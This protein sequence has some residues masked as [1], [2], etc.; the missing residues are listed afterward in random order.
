M[1]I[2]Y[3]ASHEQFT[4]RALLDYVSR[5]EKAGFKAVMCS[6]HVSPWSVRQ[7][8]SGHPWPWLGAALQATSSMSFGTLSIPGGMRYHPVAIAQNFAT[9]AQM[10]PNRFQWIAAG[11]G[12]AMNETV[13]GETWPAREERM[14]RMKA[15]IDMIRKLW[16][17]ETITQNDGPFKAENAR[18]WTLPETPPKIYAAA[19]GPETARDAG[20][21]ADGLITVRKDVDTLNSIISAF[22]EGGGEG[23]PLALQLQVAWA[24][25]EDTARTEA[26]DQWRHTAAGAQPWQDF[27]TPESIDRAAEHVAPENMDE[28]LFISAD[29]AAHLAHIREHAAFGFDEIYIHNA[30]RNQA[31]FIEVFAREVLPSC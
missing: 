28:G 18:I 7:G 26:H 23:K 6:D 19:I 9:L 24:E 10:F 15:G 11:S 14:A 22:R 5:A 25:D 30:A 17:G 16:R 21:W 1:K 2:G 31:Q 3:H 13:T 12:E 27:R 29:P 20:A 8:Q 4:P